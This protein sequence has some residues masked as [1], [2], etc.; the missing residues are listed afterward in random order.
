MRQFSIVLLQ[1]GQA[2]TLDDKRPFQFS[3]RRS[4]QIS[5]KKTVVALLLNF[6]HEWKKM[7]CPLLE[8]WK[9]K[10]LGFL[11]LRLLAL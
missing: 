11:L 10:R 1:A 7:L 8:R 5:L 3:I 6:I 9:A 2:E 4:F